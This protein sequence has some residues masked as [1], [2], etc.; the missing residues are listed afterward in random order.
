MTRGAFGHEMAG[1]NFL[2]G[3]ELIQILSLKTREK[4]GQITQLDK[5]F[6]HFLRWPVD[7]KLAISFVQMALK[8]VTETAQKAMKRST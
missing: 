8:E 6:L 5:N 1:Y 7:Q 4:G 2:E 3:Y